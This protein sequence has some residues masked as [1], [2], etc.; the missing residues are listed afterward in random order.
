MLHHCPSAQSFPPSCDGCAER[1]LQRCFRTITSA[2]F[3]VVE[4]NPAPCCAWSAGGFD[5]RLRSNSG[6][7]LGTVFCKGLFWIATQHTIRPCRVKSI[8][9][10][11][12]AP[13]TRSV[14]RALASGIEVS[15]AVSTRRGEY[16]PHNSPLQ[17]RCTRRCARWPRWRRWRRPWADGSCAGMANTTKGKPQAV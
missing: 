10:P 15:M 4:G 1:P 7:Q 6:Y 17:C 3:F 11:A 14:R 8:A 9:S 12:S 13:R 2:G 16:G 5:G